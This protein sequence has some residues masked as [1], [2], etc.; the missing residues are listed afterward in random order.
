MFL[1]QIGNEYFGE[2]GEF[3][4]GGTQMQLIT[5]LTYFK[6]LHSTI[7]KSRPPNYISVGTLDFSTL[8]LG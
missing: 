6:Y 2:M 3:P 8:H 7:D 5:T 4:D 1:L